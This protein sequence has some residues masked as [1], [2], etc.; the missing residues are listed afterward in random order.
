VTPIFGRVDDDPIVHPPGSGTGSSLQ[1]IPLRKKSSYFSTLLKWGFVGLLVF[2]GYSAWK[3]SQER[4][5]FSADSIPFLKSILAGLGDIKEYIT[6]KLGQS[7]NSSANK[8]K[9][10]NRSMMS[11]PDEEERELAAENE[12]V[13]KPNSYGTF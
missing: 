8:Q 1:S 5:K 12:L 9:N 4:G 2:V 6:G 11:T 3:N 13:V 7:H 10:T